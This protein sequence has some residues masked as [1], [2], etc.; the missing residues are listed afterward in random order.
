MALDVAVKGS[1]VKAAALCVA[2][3]VAGY[4]ISAV[5]SILYFVL[6]K[7]SPEQKASGK[8]MV[9]TALYGMAFAALGSLVGARFWRPQALGIGAA[10]A[11]TI[12][13]VALWSA[14]ETP[15]AEHWTQ[16]VAVLLMAPAAQFG[17]FFS[18]SD[19]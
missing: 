11:A 4:L 18:R 10:I 12:A 6:L 17:A 1:R 9:L 16:I 5:S 14:S 15:N 2:G 3:W 19:D 7:I 13:I 8:V